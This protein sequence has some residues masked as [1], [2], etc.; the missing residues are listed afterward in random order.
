MN[1][2]TQNAENNKYTDYKTVLTMLGLSTC[3]LL[4]STI[5]FLVKSYKQNKMLSDQLSEYNNQFMAN[6]NQPLV[7]DDSFERRLKKFFDELNVIPRQSLSNFFDQDLFASHIYTNELLNSPYSINNRFTIKE[8]DNKY[9]ITLAIPGFTKE[10]I[11]IELNGSV[12]TIF[13]KDTKQIDENDNK[14]NIHCTFKQVIS[15]KGDIDSSA[16]IHSSLH[17]GML[18]IKIP[19]I[20]Q[21]MEPKIIPIK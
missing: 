5:Y 3:L 10:Q 8:S 1:I 12:L 19:R 17:D 20:Q 4:A 6:K 2:N 16:A 18:I 14:E 21:K 9:L 11:K 15:L 13:A 7:L